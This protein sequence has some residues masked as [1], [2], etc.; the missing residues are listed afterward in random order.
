M[1]LTGQTRLPAGQP[2]RVVE[3]QKSSTVR[4]VGQFMLAP[5]TVVLV[6]DLEK[7]HNDLVDWRVVRGDIYDGESVLGELYLS[8][9]DKR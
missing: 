7:F 9:S 8:P 6:G 2:F 1:L 5:T 4:V 3:E